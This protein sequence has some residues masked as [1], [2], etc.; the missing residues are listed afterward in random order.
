MDG[1]TA[2]RHL[3]QAMDGSSARRDTEDVGPRLWATAAAARPA[4]RGPSARTAPSDGQADEE[5]FR[6][7]PTAVESGRVVPL[8]GVLRRPEAPNVGTF[9]LLQQFE[10]TVLAIGPSEFGARLVDRTHPTNPAETG[11]FSIDDV[12]EGDRP[13]LALGAVFY[14]SLGYRIAPSG[15]R[16]RVATVRFRR[17][18]AWS[19]R[20]IAAAEERAASWAY[21]FDDDE[22]T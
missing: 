10:G 18:P 19:K 5:G 20:E 16:D 2:V 15:Q 11:D 7:E 3:Q 8:R 17:L 9:I 12:S 6:A 4:Q 21:M 13:L 22:R 14:F 1:G